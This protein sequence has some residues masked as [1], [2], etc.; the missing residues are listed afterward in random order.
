M[1]KGYKMSLMDIQV[2]VGLRA[3]EDCDE[4][5]E[6]L[7]NKNCHGVVICHNAA[8]YVFREADCFA[9]HQIEQPRPKFGYNIVREF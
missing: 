5:V 2:T 7:Q 6:W 3:A 8:Y 4:V 9:D 1:D